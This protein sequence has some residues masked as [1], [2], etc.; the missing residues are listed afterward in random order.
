MYPQELTED[1]LK[2]LLTRKEFYS[3]K[4]DYDDD[5]RNPP[6]SIEL[7]ED[8]I[9]INTYQRFVGNFLN[10]NTHFRRLHLLHTTGTGK[11]LGALFIAHHFTELYKK[12]RSID[13]LTGQ[14]FVLGFGG[15]KS[16][17]TRD[18]LKYPEFGFISIREKK[19]LEQ[20]KRDSASE[21]EYDIK[22][23]RDYYNMLK[24]RIRDK[25]KGGYFTFYG[26]DEFVNRLFITDEV[27]LTD[28][29]ER[30]DD[31]HT[32]ED[33]I[34]AALSDDTIRVNKTLLKAFHNSL[35]ICDE[36]H[37]TY[38]M[39]SKNNRG[40]AV[41]YLLDT[42]DNLRF[43]SLSATPIN[44]LPT[45]VVDWMNYLV[46]KKVT[47][48]ELFENP[49]TLR[50]GALKMISSALLGKVSFLQD[51]NPRY[52]PTKKM[53]GEKLKL[54]Y[55]VEMDGTPRW[56]IPYFNFVQCEMSEYH[57]KCL[58]QYLAAT[59]NNKISTDGYS[60]FDIAIPS[61]GAC[62]FTTTGIKENILNA[63]ESWKKENKVNIT[64]TDT[65][66]VIK[67][68]F[69][70]QSNIGKYSAKFSKTIDIVLDIVKNKPGEK[71][72]IYHNRVK[73]TGVMLIQEILMQNGII[74]ELS[75]PVGNTLCSQCGR[76]LNEHSKESK[77]SKTSKM[78]KESK[79]AKTSIN[80][81]AFTPTRFV[82]AHSNIDKSSMIKSLEK[83]NAPENNFGE[84]FKII[85]GSKIIKESYDFKSIQHLLITSLPVNIP[86]F[87]Q[88][89]GRAVRKNSHIGLPL[90]KRNVNIYI[91]VSVINKKYPHEDPISPEVHRY[92]KKMID[93]LVIQKIEREVNRTA[94]D[95]DI[96][97]AINMPK[98]LE[99]TYFDSNQQLTSTQLTSTQLTS[100]QLT[101]NQSTPTQLTSNQ[102]TPTQ[103]K[104]QLGNL[105]FK[106]KY[107]VNTKLPSTA[108]FN[109]NKYFLEEI[110]KLIYIIKI[111]FT[112]NSV[113]TYDELWKIVQKP[114]IGLEVNP[115]YF[116]EDNFIIALDYLSKHG[117]TIKSENTVI[118]DLEALLDPS[119]RTIYKKTSTHAQSQAQ[120]QA[121]SHA[122]SSIQT[123]PHIIIH[124]GKYFILFPIIAREH[125]DLSNDRKIIRDKERNY[126][127]NLDEQKY[128]T[129]IDVEMYMRAEIPN[130]KKTISVNSYIQN[131]KAELNYNKTKAEL[132]ELLGDI[133]EVSNNKGSN[134]KTK[135]AKTKNT[136]IPK[137]ALRILSHLLEQTDSFQQKFIEELLMNHDEGP[138]TDFYRKMDV[139]I[140]L[141][142]IKKYDEAKK[143]FPDGFAQV[144]SVGY[145]KKD[146]A[147]LYDEKNKKWIQIDLINI[148][149]LI[150]YKEN[151]IVVGYFETVG[152]KSVFKLRLPKQLMEK[153][154]D[155]R[156]IEKGSVCGTKSKDYLTKIAANLG[157]SH[158]DKVSTL[159]TE[160][161]L[162][163][164]S[165]EITE[166]GNNSRYKYI[167]GWWNKMPKL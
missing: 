44:N 73:T 144:R 113:Y 165:S 74:D 97:R 34:L 42:I 15:T 20:R 147:K 105:Y 158:T 146:F 11:T 57:Q 54:P 19:E 117:A 145:M 31:D 129:L 7:S 23:Y 29:E 66:T 12:Q 85:L 123:S 89:V 98:D 122:Q 86:T 110:N 111:M 153:K 99:A 135:D 37:N 132:M 32:L 41:Q 39:G 9:D 8:I 16:S 10:P 24:R 36:I 70:S 28:L 128:Q 25:D 112:Q 161:M 148:N 67:G 17:F 107:V 142:E 96:H 90:D 131:G 77:E 53:I 154:A 58:H 64:V 152:Q 127:K 106:P 80:I 167:Y 126:M 75:E 60:L 140:D 81:H 109:A 124:I 78:S 149:R 114:P 33:V 49:T 84:L 30:V 79:E 108:T 103:P 139:I 162:N 102:S 151:S 72:M 56:E 101:S 87:L 115:K 121:Q 27:S 136:K 156:K 59:E 55:S 143:F 157:I 4:Y 130:L 45:E 61:P 52:Y 62:M 40:V 91:L 46:D 63:S 69:L 138:I 137:E 1:N 68:E 95:G 47:K 51:F 13:N 26:Y 18:L 133:S 43:V 118:S 134:K 14:I 116:S 22:R 164:I 5:Y 155:A 141:D 65:S 3:L 166:R 150:A 88:V 71:I 120:S 50:S 93:Y 35:L 100:T 76:S 2:D 21:S 159:C 119:M 83:F 160:I 82:I 104:P 125:S 163:L 92:I 6:D 48:K 94:F 38:N